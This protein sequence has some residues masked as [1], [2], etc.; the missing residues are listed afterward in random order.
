M[1]ASFPGDRSR[2]GTT[3][4]EVMVA[5]LILATLALAGGAMFH[6]A[7]SLLYYER[8]LQ[9]AT[10]IAASRLERL[11][12]APYHQVKPEGEDYEADFL[13]EQDEGWRNH[14]STDPAESEIC[15]GRTFP[16]VTTVRFGRL[17]EGAP[18]SYDYVVA[19]VE[20]AYGRDPESRVRMQTMLAP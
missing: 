1:N 11:R 2:R 3:L 18:T 14:G 7:R 16:I 19:T 17:E 12:V 6:R 8:N 9:A 20:V 4:I 15:N 10:D 5:A 13:E